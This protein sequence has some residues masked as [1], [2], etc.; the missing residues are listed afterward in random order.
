MFM[1]VPAHL[2]IL[3]N[4]RADKLAKQAVKREAVEVTLSCQSQ[5]AEA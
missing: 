4:E 5:R 3:G 1:R 2:G